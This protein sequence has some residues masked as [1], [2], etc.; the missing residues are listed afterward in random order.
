M[1]S[2]FS[3]GQV[4]IARLVLVLFLLESCSNR[5]IQIQPQLDRKIPKQPIT[6]SHLQLIRTNSSGIDAAFNPLQTL[7]SQTSMELDNDINQYQQAKEQHN[8]IKVTLENEAPRNNL[9]KSSQ[10]VDL[11]QP[12]YQK[13][14]SVGRRSKQSSHVPINKVSKENTYSIRNQTLPKNQNAPVRK[15]VGKQ[16]SKVSQ[17]LAGLLANQ[18]CIAQGDYQ[19]TF[20]KEEA[21][22]LQAVVKRNY[23]AG[24]TREVLPVIMLPNLVYST[25]TVKNKT[26]QQQ[27]IH[28]KKNGVYVGNRGLLGG[29]RTCTGLDLEPSFEQALL[30]QLPQGYKLG[31]AYDQGDCFFDALAQCLNKIKNIDVNTVKY[32]RSEC[33]IFYKDNKAKVDKWNQADYGGLDKGKDEY[34]MIQYTAEECEQHFNGRSPIWG[35]PSV[36]GQILCRKLNLGGICS[37]EVYKNPDDSSKPVVSYHLVNGKNYK[38][39]SEE[40]GRALIQAGGIPIIINVQGNLH[41]VP[42]LQVSPHRLKNSQLFSKKKKDEKGKEKVGSDE[43][44]DESEMEEETDN[45]ASEEKTEGD[46]EDREGIEEAESDELAVPYIEEEEKDIHYFPRC[47]Y[48]TRYAG[49]THFAMEDYKHWG[50]YFRSTRRGV[51][52][53]YTRF[54]LKSKTFKNLTLNVGDG[55]SYHAHTGTFHNPYKFEEYRKRVEK[56]TE[57]Q[58]EKLEEEQGLI[59]SIQ[60]FDLNNP[61]YEELLD[62]RNQ[63]CS[64][65]RERALELLPDT[66]ERFEIIHHNE[67][68]YLLIKIPFIQ[69]FKNTESLNQLFMAY[70]VA[71]INKEAKKAGI[72]IELVIRSSFGHLLPSIDVTSNSFRINVGIVPECYGEVIARSLAILYDIIINKLSNVDFERYGYGEEEEDFIAKINNKIRNYNNLKPTDKFLPEWGKTQKCYEILQL[73]GDPSGKSVA[74]Q[75]TRTRAY[76]DLLADYVTEELDKEEPDLAL[77]I[78]TMLGYLE[79][80]KEVSMSIDQTYFRRNIREWPIQQNILIQQD[81]QFWKLIT[82]AVKS[83]G[84]RPEVYLDKKV[85]GL[86]SKLE[87]ANKEF[88][89]RSASTMSA[90]DGLGSDSEYEGKT[91]KDQCLYWHKITVTTGMMAINVAHYLARYYL[92]QYLGIEQYRTECRNMYYET[93]EVLNLSVKRESRLAVLNNHKQKNTSTIL[94]FDLNHCDASGTGG[95][96][97][98]YYVDGSLVGKHIPIVVMDCTSSTSRH[99]KCAIN[100]AIIAGAKLILLVGSGL[101]NEQL[102]ADNNPYGT[103]RI[104]ALGKKQRNELYKQA[105]AV[106]KDNGGIPAT[107]HKIRKGYKSAGLILTNQLIANADVEDFNF[108]EEDELGLAKLFTSLYEVRRYKQTLLEQIE[109]LSR[110]PIQISQERRKLIGEAR[111]SELE[112]ETVIGHIENILCG[113]IV[114]E[115]K[116]FMENRIKEEFKEEEKFY[117]KEWEEYEPLRQQYE[118]GDYDGWDEWDWEGPVEPQPPRCVTHEE[119]A[120][121]YGDLDDLENLIEISGI[122]DDTLSQ[123]LYD[124]FISIDGIDNIIEAL[125]S[126]HNTLNLKPEL[127]RMIL[128]GCDVQFYDVDP[129][130]EGFLVRYLKESIEE[131]FKEIEK[132][133]KTDRNKQGFT[134]L[135]IA[136]Q[137]NNKAEVKQLLFE[138][139]IDIND[140][141]NR[142]GDTPLHLAAAVGNLEIVELLVDRGADIRAKNKFGKTP[143]HEAISRDSLKF[144]A[145]VDLLQGRS[146]SGYIDLLN[147]F[148]TQSVINFLLQKE[149]NIQAETENSSFPLHTAAKHGNAKVAHLLIAKGLDV[150]ARDNTG[151]GTP[152]H[153]AVSNGHVDV[154]ELLLKQGADANVK[155]M[156]GD[157]PLHKVASSA[158]CTSERWLQYMQII[159]LLCAYGAKDYTQHKNNY[160]FT[161]LEIAQRMEKVEI[162]ELL[163]ILVQKALH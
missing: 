107:A 150:N 142:S 79:F 93:G 113:L 65:V 48:Y 161:A 18:T 38:S 24:F 77:P 39:I 151:G 157:M 112:Q 14:S 80:G 144:R 68:P 72:P 110:K 87:R 114:D 21:R 95:N 141:E 156:L 42:L 163:T 78:A 89:I 30:D 120:A 15:K 148:D 34:Y 127:V 130:E 160:G 124:D 54:N 91:L 131:Q 149:A 10:A 45:D 115:L 19:V 98:K 159:N 82:R 101:K 53:R 12:S 105:K 32:L 28:V 26:W 103:V 71:I 37:I 57:F 90:E 152:L 50:T 119:I 108:D 84:G 134:R 31:T 128:E 86:Y 83:I 25:S 147:K 122:K 2:S 16:A 158:L 126:E 1:G 40:D 88:I 102:G 35:R 136:V 49:T 117:E 29:G 74:C 67:Y 73:K 8:N 56:P 58:S 11:M 63:I 3:K 97:L 13:L 104:I 60:R 143:L 99:I 76:I 5:N 146:D 47:E 92:K 59:E 154:V 85:F 66:S 62:Y 133:H 123:M 121:G 43:D 137:K 125:K 22:G 9:R 46:E 41:F 106:L 139:E 55:N 94:F 64:Q 155:D 111:A 109:L 44:I 135:H 162:V 129:T 33:H 52:G 17:G 138:S 7:D 36:E 145:S 61:L 116:P 27:H 20:E 70:Y 153:I 51:S 23:S 69:K 75:F 81:K 118:D 100:D 132:S 96:R 6:S 140:Q 4:I